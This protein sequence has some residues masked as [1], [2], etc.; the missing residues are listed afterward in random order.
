MSPFE[1]IGWAL[2]AAAS[3]LIVGITFVVVAA[4]GRGLKNRE[5]NQ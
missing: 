3:I 4:I 5:Q 2:A 1:L